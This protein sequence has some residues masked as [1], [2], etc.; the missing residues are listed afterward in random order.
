[1]AVLSLPVVLFWSAPDPL[2][3][4]RLPAV[5]KPSAPAPVAVFS[6]PVVVLASAP[7]PRNV[8]AFVSQPSSQTALACGESAKQASA[9]V[10]RRKPDR[11]GDQPI[12]F[13]RCRVGIFFGFLVVAVELL[14][15][16]MTRPRYFYP[17]R[18]RRV[19][20][21]NLLG[22]QGVAFVNTEASGLGCQAASLTRR[23][24]ALHL[25]RVLINSGR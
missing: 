24:F 5:F 17:I 3:V 25:Y 18:R 22:T 14:K 23:G 13:C 8:L 15:R 19:K 2:A 4:L 21:S 10:M 7:S 16:R 6:A 20:L 1:M 9:S 12:D 11:K